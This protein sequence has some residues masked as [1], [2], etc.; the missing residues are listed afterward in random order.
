MKL[1][2]DGMHEGQQARNVTHEEW[3]TRGNDPVRNMRAMWETRVIASARVLSIGVEEDIL[4]SLLE[5]GTEDC[6]S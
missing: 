2:R 3:D 1:N 6:F 5:L 4:L